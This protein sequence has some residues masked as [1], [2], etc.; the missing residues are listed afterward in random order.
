ME[1]DEYKRNEYL[2]ETKN[3]KIEGIIYVDES[4]INKNIIKETAWIKK[5]DNI[6]QEVLGKKHSRTTIMAGLNL[7]DGIVS[8]IYFKGNT[9]TEIFINWL[10]E[11]LLPKTRVGQVIV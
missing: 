3:I 10:K 8:H 2:E 11:E 6:I 9:N 1:K 7:K 5:G 4:G